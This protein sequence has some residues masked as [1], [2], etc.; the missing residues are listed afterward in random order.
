LNL[1]EEQSRAVFLGTLVNDFRERRKLE[2]PINPV[3]LHELA[4]LFDLGQPGA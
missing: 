4:Q 3:D 1:I 2:V